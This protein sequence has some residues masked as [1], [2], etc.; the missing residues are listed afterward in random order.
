MPVTELIKLV[1]ALI[2]LLAA[3]LGFL[4]GPTRRK[5]DEAPERG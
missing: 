3:L 2:Q 4:K 1:A 5:N